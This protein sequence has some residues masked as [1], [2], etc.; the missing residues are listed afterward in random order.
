MVLCLAFGAL[1]AQGAELLPLR[2]GVVASVSLIAAALFMRK[3]WAEQRRVTGDDPSGAE[4]NLWLYLSGTAIIV[5]FVLV[6]LLTPGSEI[7]RRSGDTGGYDSWLMLGGGLIAWVLLY[8]RGSPRDE[9]DHA[10]AAYGDRVG[11]YALIG[12]LIVFLLSLAFVPGAWKLRFTHWLIA[13]ALLWQIM[14][15]NLIQYCA[16]LYRYRLAAWPQR[17]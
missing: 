10:I 12:L 11:Y 9:R 14:L 13:N 7:H 2:P 15:A 6:V 17:R 4:R 1:L 3:R 5:G 8:Q 16:Q